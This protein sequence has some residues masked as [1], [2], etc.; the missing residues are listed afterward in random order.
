MDHSSIG[1]LSEAK[2]DTGVVEPPKLKE[3]KRIVIKNI[4]NKQRVWPQKLKSQ[5]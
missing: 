3:R 4:I 2:Q 1:T 5:K